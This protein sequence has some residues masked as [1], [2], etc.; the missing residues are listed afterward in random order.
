V[1]LDVMF[2]APS[3]KDITEITI[4]AEMIEKGVRLPEP[5]VIATTQTL[6]PPSEQEPRRESA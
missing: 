3:R 2:E 6:P 4:S 5:K 1:M